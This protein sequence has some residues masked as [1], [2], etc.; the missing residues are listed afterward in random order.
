MAWSEVTSDG[1]TWGS[2]SGG[3]SLTWNDGTVSDTTTR[4][5]SRFVLYNQSSGSVYGGV[6]FGVH[7]RSTAADARGVAFL[8]TTDDP[9]KIYDSG[10][11][12]I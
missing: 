9:V 1:G 7:L 4:N 8:I 6:D 2:E 11:S 12:L 10:D 5:T 3:T